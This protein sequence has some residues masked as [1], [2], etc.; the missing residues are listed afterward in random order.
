MT[1][2]VSPFAQFFDT[3]GAPLNNGAIYIGT[4]YL[5][6]QTNP[7]AVY[8]DDALTI[9]AFQPI[10]TLNGYPVW[11]GAPA[12]IFC[13]ADN[14]SITVQTNTGRTVWAVQDATSVPTLSES[15]GASMVGFIAAGINAVT[16]TVQG[17]LRDT[18]SV[19]D[20]GAV[21]DGVTNDT[22]AFQ[23]ALS[24]AQNTLTELFI[25]AGNYRLTAQLS[26][27]SAIKMRVTGA[28]KGV[29][30]LIWDA[31][32]TNGGGISLT[33]AD[34]LNPCDISGVSLLTKANGVGTA[35][36]ITGQNAP[37]VTVLGPNVADIDIIGF[38]KASHCWT[39]GAQFIV[40]WYICLTRVS[41]KGREETAPPFT[42]QSGII[43]T[44]CQ[45]IFADKFSV[46]HVQ[47]AVLEQNVSAVRGEGFSFN[48][49]ELVGVN[50]GFEMTAGAVAPGTNIG[51]GHINSY[52]IGIN[53]A[54][55]YQTSIHDVLFYKTF[56]ST[57]NY[58]GI[59][60]QNCNSNAIHDNQFHGWVDATGDTIGISISGSGTSDLNGIHDNLFR[61]FYGTNRIGI[62]VSTGAGNNN[63][64]NNQG[65]ATVATV[66][67]VDASAEKNNLF[68][69]NF[70][71]QIQ[72]FPANAATPSVGNDLNGQWNSNNSV[73][74]VVTNFLDGYTGQTFTL[75]INDSNTTLQHNAGLILKNSI[76]YAPPNGT[77]M[78]FRRDATLWREVSRSV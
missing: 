33:Y 43:L 29:T 69:R 2:I 12:R 31:G 72:T 77:I 22:A 23:N 74:T 18:V 11:N 6:A 44:D 7:I 4:A 59:Q 50:V 52:S 45:V 25:P 65:D 51:P 64:H 28:G 26:A 68:S 20:F 35:L 21:G 76:S 53:I 36:T 5:D 71:T 30:N 78:V 39:A 60:I 24:Y 73:A 58:V 8:W 34:W 37:S 48:D 46:I 38:D 15:N 9:P 14:F 67:Q 27:N 42:Q 62:I 66:V 55:Q 63:I 1:E 70:P 54:N 41:I 10:R 57:S 47:N 3:S 13:N 16:R 32:S 56:N 61:N 17:K 75:L 19:K 40:C 49:F